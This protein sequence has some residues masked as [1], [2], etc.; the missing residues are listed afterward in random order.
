MKTFISLMLLPLLVLACQA[1]PGSKKVP[2]RER[3]IIKNGNVQSFNP[4]IDVLFIV[5]DSGSMSSHQ[6]HF[7]AN[8]NIFIQE[9]LKSQFIDYH[10][11][12]TTSS[13]TG[14][15]STGSKAPDGELMS[16]SGVNFVANTTKFG[17]EYLAQLLKVGTSGA[18]SEEFLSIPPLT[19]SNLNIN[20]VNKG[21]YRDDAQLAIFV[22]TDAV[23]QSDVTSEHAIEFLVDLKGGDS[24]KIHYAAAIID[25]VFDSSCRHDSFSN[26]D[27][28]KMKAVINFFQERGSMF[29]LCSKNYG[30]SMAKVAKDIVKAVST[31]NL[32]KLPDIRTIK[33]KLGDKEIVEGENGWS[34]NDETNSI[35]IS[36]KLNITA[37][38]ASKLSVHFE[39]FFKKE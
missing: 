20:G 11:G 13:V 31:I 27:A 17:E 18:G 24:R 36:P 19:F 29:E 39:D 32:D 16:Y 10:I 3:K 28:V 8:A 12:V 6:T 37:K 22:I 25:Q 23:D 21:F 1:E 15:F 26:K 34:Y 33:V 35:K 7:S 2:K 30:E 38:D 4:K 9:I 14:T 5:D